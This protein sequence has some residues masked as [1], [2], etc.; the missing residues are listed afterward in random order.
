[1]IDLM[2]AIALATYANARPANNYWDIEKSENGCLAHQIFEGQ[3]STN[4]GI[5]LE[6]DGTLALVVNNQ[7]W[8]TV[9]R[10][11]YPEISASVNGSRYFGTGTV[12]RRVDGRG[13]FVMTL[14]T[15]F[16]SDFAQGRTLTLTNGNIIVD[17]LN[18]GGSAAATMDLYKCVD[19]MRREFDATERERQ[20]LAH[21]PVDP[22]S[23]PTDTP[24][25]KSLDIVEPFWSRTPRITERDF[26]QRAL[27]HGVDGSATIQCAVASSGRPEG[28]Q[29]I[30]ELP[31][32][33]GFGTAALRIVQRAQLSP[34]TVDAAIEGQKFQHRIEFD[35]GK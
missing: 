14:P 21:I 24:P 29:I 11:L 3:G 26:P 15:Q 7:N 28:C 17:E 16:L 9:D 32:G 33:Y 23:S 1:M 5:K 6:I 22:F 18:L 20:R 19:A 13:G 2:L 30:S 35:I 10:Q 27:D 8:S 12:G 34:R 31:V 4:L 25:S